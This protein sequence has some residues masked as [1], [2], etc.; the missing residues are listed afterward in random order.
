MWKFCKRHVPKKYLYPGLVL[1]IALGVLF[2]Y[3]IWNSL[4]D[5]IDSV[6]GG[7]TV[8]CPANGVKTTKEA[9]ERRPF[10]VMIENSIAARPQ[11]GLDQADV[12][13]EALAE[14]GITRMM[15]I[16]ACSGDNAS[17]I[18]PVRSARS[19]FVDWVE[20][21]E[22]IYA[23]AGGSP[24]ALSLIDEDEILDLQNFGDGIY[25]WRSRDRSSPHNLYTSYEGLKG[26]AEK[27]GYDL[28]GDYKELTF[29]DDIAV[30]E[31]PEGQEIV[32]NFSSYNYRVGWVYQ[33][34]SNSYLRYL[35][36]EADRDLVSDKQIIAKTIIVMRIK[37][38][39]MNNNS[40]RLYMDTTG[41]GQALIF[42]DGQVIEGS[43]EKKFKGDRETF[44]DQNGEEMALNRG[45]IWIEIVKPETKIDY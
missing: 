11:S 36:Q 29:K 17:S 13:Y 1:L 31:R 10:A 18:G 2:A 32:V 8:Y 14:G 35:A 9:A 34:T 19:Y 28:E 38:N 3:W 43:W 41:S 7:E 22:A 25:F 15:A 5:K 44:Y 33:K 16:Y 12:V 6:G 45:Q 30:P 40:Q 27:L 24:D 4:E 26:F 39:L 21:W 37:Q 23:H 42:Q 20:G